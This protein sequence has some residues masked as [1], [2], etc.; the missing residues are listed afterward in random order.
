MGRQE[1]F[2]QLQ[3][4]IL[5]H[6]RQ[7]ITDLS[8]DLRELWKEIKD[9]DKMKANL[10][11]IL[12]EHTRELQQKFP[13]LFA[14]FI[15]NA[16]KHSMHA[17]QDEMIDALYPITGKLVKRYVTKELELLSEKIDRRI[18][19]T[20]SI[21]IWWQYIKSF[22][23]G[24]KPGDAMLVNLQKPIV[25]QVFVI[26]QN[27]GILLGSYSKSGDFDQDMVAGMLTAIKNFAK[28]TFKKENEELELIE[29]GTAKIFLKNLRTFYIAVVI[30]GITDK[31][32]LSDLDDNLWDFAQKIMSNNLEDNE[33]NST[34]EELHEVSQE[35]IAQQIESYFKQINNDQ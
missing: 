35:K 12:L 10:D 33:T 9:T 30:N 4:L 18:D 6:D 23:T 5:E 17:A 15:A 25:E 19:K 14:P 21:E 29:Y 20:F 11:P 31:Q 32:F 16:I 22:F 8:A 34:Q 24:K 3:A 27:S 7:Q 13:D 1:A 26:E 28:D 2:E